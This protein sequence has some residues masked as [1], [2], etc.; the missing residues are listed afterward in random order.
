MDMSVKAILGPTSP[1]AGQRPEKLSHLL[2]VTQAESGTG[3]VGETV[4]RTGVCRGGMRES[5][6]Q[7]LGTMAEC[8]SESSG[9]SPQN[10]QE[11]PRPGRERKGEVVQGLGHREMKGCGLAAISS[12]KRKPFRGPGR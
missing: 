6:V 4:L 12:P 10:S 1:A 5:W 11:A 8:S 7:F 2:K 3:E 9:G